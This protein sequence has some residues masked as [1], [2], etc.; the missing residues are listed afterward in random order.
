MTDQR[1]QIDVETL[2]R[3]AY[4]DELPKKFTSSAEGIWAQI[5]QHGHFGVDTYRG[6]PQRYFNFG[7]PHPD[8]IVIEK[9][10]ARLE[11]SP[12]DWEADAEDILGDLFNLWKPPIPSAKPA[13]RVSEIGWG[14]GPFRVHERVE[15][16]RLVCEVILRPAALVTMHARMGTRPDWFDGWPKPE[17]VPADRGPN[18]KII[19]ECWGKNAYSAGS[20]CPLAWD[21]SITSIAE[22]RADYLAWWRGLAHLADTLELSGHIVLPPTAP[23]MPWRNRDHPP[24]I[25]AMPRPPMSRLP[26]GPQRP[27]MGPPLRIAKAGKVRNVTE[28]TQ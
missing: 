19:G 21:P 14:K 20:N 24:N 13:R 18:A 25:I 28:N 1:R 26:L 12:L 6:S 15:P 5:E 10:V 4:R 23:E 17:Q 9:A 22:D 27:T 7:L 11:D 16:S 8:A 2:L 3:W